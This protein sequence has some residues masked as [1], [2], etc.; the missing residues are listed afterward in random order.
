MAKRLTEYLEQIGL[1]IHDTAY[2]DASGVFRAITKDE[3]LAREVWK[4]AL[5][6]E[7]ETENSDGTVRHRIYPADPKMQQ[8]I[9]ERREGKNVVPTGEETASLLDKISDLAKSKVNNAA[10]ESVDD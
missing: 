6:Y 1:E 2:A 9:F 8:F 3:Q 10:K 4:R 7:E 5:G